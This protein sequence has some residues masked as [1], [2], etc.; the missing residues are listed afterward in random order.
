MGEREG[1]SPGEEVL[2]PSG[3]CEC[4]ADVDQKEADNI[5]QQPEMQTTVIAPIWEL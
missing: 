4:W 5:E 2:L 3:I 1:K